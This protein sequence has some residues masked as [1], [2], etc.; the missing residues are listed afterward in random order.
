MH[1]PAVPT[2]Y[3]SYVYEVYTY[4]GTYFGKYD[5]QYLLIQFFK[6]SMVVGMLACIHAGNP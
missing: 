2:Q 6:A 4:L 1:V 5:N 3:L